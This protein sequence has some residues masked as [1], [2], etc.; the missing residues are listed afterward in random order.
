MVEDDAGA[1]ASAVVHGPNGY[2]LTAHAALV[3]ARARV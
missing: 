1:A 3:I 2:L